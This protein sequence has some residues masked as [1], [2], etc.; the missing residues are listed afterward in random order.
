MA[1]TS[2]CGL[3][4][5]QFYTECQADDNSVKQINKIWIVLDYLHN[6]RH[7]D[8]TDLSGDGGTGALGP[9]E[10]LYQERISLHSLHSLRLTG[11][12]DTAILRKLLYAEGQPE[13]KHLSLDNIQVPREL[14]CRVKNIAVLN[15]G[16]SI[17]DS[18][19]ML[20]TDVFPFWDWPQAFVK[21]HNLFDWPLEMKFNRL[22]SL[23]FSVV[24]PSYSS[25][26]F[27]FDREMN[28]TKYALCGRLV[29]ENRAT[30][31]R[32]VFEQGP[33][34]DRQEEVEVHPLRYMDGLFY[35]YL[36]P[37]LINKSWPSLRVME[38][39]GVGSWHAHPRRATAVPLKEQKATPLD[40]YKVQ[41][42]QAAI[43]GQ[44]KLI[45]TEKS[46]EFDHLSLREV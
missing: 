30:L 26:F 14:L 29:Q 28:T 9:Y 6:I 27:T 31:Q 19:N 7:V 12:L 24:S 11:T 36:Y 17:L 33:K 35:L 10:G 25:E 37:T 18:Q 34:P 39:K 2:R 32:F 38:L 5:N 15:H 44:A 42:I 8:I 46:R 23:S 45:V 22:T 41:F 16:P 20:S 13:I 40:E 4:F 43:G 3:N 1:T 21:E